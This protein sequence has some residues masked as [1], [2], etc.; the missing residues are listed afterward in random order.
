[1]KAAVLQAVNQ[2][3][4]I[5]EIDIRKPLHGEVLVRTVAS[6]VCHSDLHFIDG[7]WP[8]PLP[9]VL[10]HEAAGVVEE[11]GDG[12]TYVRPGDHVVLSFAP[13]CGYCR[14]CVSGNPQLCTNPAARFP[15]GREAPPRLSWQGKPVNQFANLSSFAEYMVVPENGVVKVPQEM[16][17]DK[18]A[19]I[20]CSVTT[21]IGAVINTAK[22]AEGETVAVIGTGGV[23]LNV[24]QGA[25]LASA[26]K[27]I[28]V[29]VLDNKLAYAK[30]MG[31][32][33]TVNAAK[34]DP[35][36]AVQDLT[37][38]FGVDYA[39]E[40]I[41]NPKAG[42]QAF[43][44]V[45]RGGTAVIV[46]MMPFDSVVE[47]PGP[48]FLG[49]KK[50]IGCFYGSTRFRVDMPRLCEFYLQGKIKLDELV[51][52]RYDL[53]QVNEA[54]EAMKKGEVARSIMPISAA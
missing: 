30:T 18:A 48:A 8:T 51:T 33:H 28:A 47:L 6:G 53:A 19:L 45:R 50:A 5:E 27:I 16:P 2:P 21:G 1:V 54:F 35:V 46:G 49:E 20:G 23:G 26:S 37:G 12:V 34:D 4:T 29:D 7:L 3:M 36:K 40:A 11:I 42:R 52:R 24:I 39:F 13:F 38:G 22:V 15:A 43:E 44:M 25:V 32:T 14:D 31:A 17:L 9:V 10:G 41:G